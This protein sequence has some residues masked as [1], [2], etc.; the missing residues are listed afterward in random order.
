MDYRTIHGRTYHSDKH[1]T[2]YWGPNDDPQNDAMDIN[3]HVLTLQLKGKLH[4]APLRKDI[5]KVLDVGTGTGIW[6]IDF[7][8]EYPEAQVIG[9]DLSPIQP[10]WVPPNCKFEI[11]D[12]ELPWTWPDGTFDY[13]HMRY[14]VGA[15]GDWPRLFRQAYA[16]LK[17]GGYIETFE[18]DAAFMSD[19]GTVPPDSPLVRWTTMN[20]EGGRRLGK[21]F[22]VVSDDLQVK[23]LQEA[24]FADITVKNLKVRKK[25]PHPPLPPFP[26]PLSSPGRNQKNS[27]VV[28]GT[29]LTPLVGPDRSLAGGP[30]TQR[31]RPV[32]AIRHRS[33]Y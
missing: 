16:A 20:I 19:D 29:S 7:A 33:G 14:L 28:A 31:H 17:P 32:F 10:Y 12:A 4:L 22:T 25:T 30:G 13:V 27:P 1:A 11:D 8:D 18:P 26:S 23:G 9:T 5:Q 24:G 15:V 3:H 2:R 21:P 6:A